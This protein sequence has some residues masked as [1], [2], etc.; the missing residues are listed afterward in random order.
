MI[1]FTPDKIILGCTHYP[2]L[3]HLLE[4]YAHKDL[5]IDPAKIF[6]EYIKNDLQNSN[7]LN[8]SN[9]YGFEKMFVSANPESFVKNSEIF[10]SVKNKPEVVLN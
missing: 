6:V 8:D 1:E 7:L 4:N 5:F 9:D 2:Y 3:L 10:Y